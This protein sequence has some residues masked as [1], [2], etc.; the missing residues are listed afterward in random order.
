MTTAPEA[1][2][3]AVLAVIILAFSSYCII[4]RTPVELRDDR[5]AWFFGFL[6]GVFGGA[7]GM[8]GPP[9]VIYGALRRW[10]PDQFRATLQGYFLPASLVGLA[11]FTYE[12]LWTIDVTIYYLISLPAIL[13]AIFVGRVIHRRLRDNRFLIYIHIG[14]IVVGLLLLTQ[15]LWPAVNPANAE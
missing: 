8:N 4:K 13:A 9:L 10:S 15:A 11:G 12:G 7:Y 14:L 1:V 3:K 2:V 5:F 6:A